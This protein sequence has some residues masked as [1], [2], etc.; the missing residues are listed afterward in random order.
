MNAIHNTRDRPRLPCR[1]LGCEKTYLNKR[2]VVIH[3]RIEHVEN[4]VR[5]RCTLCRKEFKS[6]REVQGHI[7][8]HTTEKL[9]TCATCGKSFAQRE[10]MKSHEKIHLEKSARDRSKCSVCPQTFLTRHGLQ[11]HFRAVHENQRNYP[12]PL[13]DK[14]FTQPSNLKRH[15]EGQHAANKE[16]VHSCDRCEDKTHSKRNLARHRANLQKYTKGIHST[17][18]RP[19]LPCGFLGCE[20]TF[21]N[22]GNISRH[23]NNVHAQNPVRFPCTLCGK[24]FK[25]RGE[26][27]NHIPTHTTEKP[28]KCGTC[29]RNFTYKSALTRHEITH[30]E[31]STRDM[32]QCQVCPQTFLSRTNLKSHIR[33]VHENQRNYP[34]PLCDKRF[35]NSSNLKRHVVAHHA[36][37]KELVHSCDKCEYKSHSKANLACHRKRH[38]AARHGCYFCAKKFVLFSE[39]V[40]HCR[41]HTLEKLRYLRM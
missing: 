14:R 18:E 6:R 29:G 4:P 31:K 8:T 24:G 34:C 10:A 39:L 32:L 9:Y 38:N 37:N 3:E 27:E 23:V 22:K 7:L 11:G 25:A 36:A 20:K 40:R 17:S 30:L 41:I 28:Y 12:C 26:L 13:C 16:L 21:L 15:V 35:A 2:D 5:F 33:A 19:R 1:F